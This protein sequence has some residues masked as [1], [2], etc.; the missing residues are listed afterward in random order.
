MI[1]TTDL[2]QE[3]FSKLKNYVP[4]HLS[5]V[6]EMV[7]LLQLSYDSVYRRIRG[8]KPISLDELK[9]ICDHFKVSLDTLLQ[10]KSNAVLFFRDEGGE[11]KTDFTA[12]LKGILQQMKYFNSFSSR[13]MYY[14]CKDAP[15][16]HFYLF[17][18]MAAFKT[19]FWLRSVINDPI[20]ANEKFDL[21][22]HAF[23]DCYL[24]GQEIIKEY[25][26]ISSVE[27]WNYESFNSTINQIEFYRDAGLFRSQQDME[28]VAGSLIRIF[29]YL[30]NVAM[31]GLKPATGR[32]ERQEIRFYINEVILGSNTILLN[33]NDQRMS[34][35]TYS[36]LKYLIS[37]DHQLCED[38]FTTFNNLKNRSILI[39]QAGEKERSRYFNSLREKVMKIMG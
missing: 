38:T 19:F 13:T 26:S 22:K 2:Q 37:R 4:P 15:I 25:N 30:E 29:D 20:Y 17:P 14:L 1:A 31:A 36:V 23:H 21:E 5:L 8:E 11:I 9:L 16:F 34:I 24:I 33:L 7:D 39:S 10:L 27:M 18:E 35:L 3:F 12:Y 6:D 28:A 32:M